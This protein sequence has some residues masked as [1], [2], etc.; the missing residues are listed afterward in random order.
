LSAEAFSANITDDDLVA[1][2]KQTG[3]SALPRHF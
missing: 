1:E 3:L 2:P